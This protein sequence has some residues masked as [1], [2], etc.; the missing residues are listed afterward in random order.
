MS[1]PPIF[2]TTVNLPADLISGDMDLVTTTAKTV[3]FR[4]A[5]TGKLATGHGVSAT[6]TCAWSAG[7]GAWLLSMV[8][9]KYEGHLYGAKTGANVVGCIVDVDASGTPKVDVIAD[10]TVVLDGADLC[11][12]D[13]SADLDVLLVDASAVTAGLHF[14][15]ICATGNTATLAAAYI[16]L[17]Y[18]VVLT[19][20]SVF[21]QAGA[22]ADYVWTLPGNWLVQG[23][24]VH[25]KK[26]F[27]HLVDTA[28]AGVER[29]VHI[30]TNEA[31][32]ATHWSM[33]AGDYILPVEHASTTVS[34]YL[35][36]AG[37]SVRAYVW[38]FGDEDMS[39]TTSA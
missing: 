34:F 8:S 5:G 19:V 31:A 9:F 20:A 2:G 15:A 29:I 25:A 7:D 37:N 32:G 35:E 11:G 1:A 12:V 16:A 22:G 13:G 24:A 4:K 26:M 27:I 23:D 39:G 28:P 21:V 10:A 3:T 6:P 33:T 38:A 18:K 14:T 17:G 36:T 30:T